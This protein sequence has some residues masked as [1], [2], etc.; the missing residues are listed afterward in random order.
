MY[1]FGKFGNAFIQK[2]DEYSFSIYL[3]HTTC[4]EF[5]ALLRDRLG[6][7]IVVVAGLSAISTIFLTIVLHNLVEKNFLKLKRG[8]KNAY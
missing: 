4:L 5:F 6:L 2:F 7:N 8:R 3:A 1:S